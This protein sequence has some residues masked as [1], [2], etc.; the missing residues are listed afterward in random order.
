MSAAALVLDVVADVEL[1]VDWGHVD[2]L[3]L[4]VMSFSSSVLGCAVESVLLSGLGCVVGSVSL[5][6]LGCAV[7][8]AVVARSESLLAVLVEGLSVGEKTIKILVPDKGFKINTKLCVYEI[9]T[10]VSINSGL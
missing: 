10:T 8:A 5:S 7:A 6:V 3:G 9:Q 4:S 2:V 1:Q